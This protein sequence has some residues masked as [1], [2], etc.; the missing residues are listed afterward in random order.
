MAEIELNSGMLDGE[1]G[2]AIKKLIT[3][4]MVDDYD[5]CIKE[6][7]SAI[8][9]RGHMISEFTNDDAPMGFPAFDDAGE[10]N[11]LQYLDKHKIISF[12][13]Q[14]AL[15]LEV[16]TDKG[17]RLNSAA[18]KRIA[19]EWSGKYDG[20]SRELE[21]VLTQVLLHPN[22]RLA[23]VGGIQDQ[24]N[25]RRDPVVKMLRTGHSWL[26]LDSNIETVKGFIESY[27]T[28]ERYWPLELWEIAAV[29]EYGRSDSFAASITNAC[30]GYLNTLL[31]KARMFSD[32]TATQKKG[33]ILAIYAIS[34]L[35]STRTVIAPFD[36]AIPKL[37]SYINFGRL[38]HHGLC[39]SQ[40]KASPIYEIAKGV[41]LNLGE[42]VGSS[43]GEIIYAGIKSIIETVGYDI[44][45]IDDL[46]GSMR[47][48]YARL[49]TDRVVKLVMEI[50]D[51]I[52]ILESPDC[53]YVFTDEGKSF[54]NDLREDLFTWLKYL[55]SDDIKK[56]NDISKLSADDAATY[57]Y[58]VGKF[59]GI[60]ADNPYTVTFADHLAS[61][62]L[63]IEKL[64]RQA[65]EAIVE[66][67]TETLMSVTKQLN[68][69]KTSA[70]SILIELYNPLRLTEAMKDGA[71]K[72]EASPKNGND[73]HDQLLDD[74]EHTITTLE[75]KLADETESRS[76]LGKELAE[77]KRNIKA[78]E[79][80]LADASDDSSDAFVALLRGST[81]HAVVS[82]FK[83][84]AGNHV[85]VLD[86]ALESASKSTFK[87]TA[88]LMEA[89]SILSDDYYNQIVNEGKPDSVAK[90]VLG[91]AYRAG[92]S[93]T[94]IAVPKLRAQREFKYE[95]E[96]YLFVQH[97]TL[98]TK[99]GNQTSLQVH[100]KIIDKKLV[101]ARVGTH[102]DVS[103][104]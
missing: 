8:A 39:D 80:A 60:L 81:P 97:L 32:L 101:I 40:G 73:G 103:S 57:D 85:V 14:V 79:K 89:L 58:W 35:L 78:M 21:L 37:D 56:G 83:A 20:H 43:K 98:G 63:N 6:Q 70:Q 62:N 69:A 72:K 28:D 25:W 4:A 18:R 86:S 44:S 15:A 102:L 10:L 91:F 34:S 9:I 48:Y 45:K 1:M 27:K 42:S 30:E 96:N 82:S 26:G 3:S 38:R 71:P 75:D 29:D 2:N 95:G 99:R 90:N 50:E 52:E 77:A 93:D 13:D 11:L 24:K 41:A 74:L 59:R 65:Q 76:A 64:Q 55:R 36:A 16:L 54:L 31:V 5:G 47:A 19:K 33:L 92:E 23:I 104:S 7:N 53:H 67:D 87:H 22:A 94:T 49:L 68:E 88:K 66:M 12:D 51:I 17:G 61:R 46:K 100:F 84:L